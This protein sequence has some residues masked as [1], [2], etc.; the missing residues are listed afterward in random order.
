MKA[1][2]AIRNL[3]SMMLS[4]LRSCERGWD[5]RHRSGGI[6]APVRRYVPECGSDAS[7][8]SSRGSCSEAPGIVPPLSSV[9]IKL[10]EA[11]AEIGD[12]DEPIGDEASSSRLGVA[13]MRALED[14]IAI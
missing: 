13:F 10:K 2:S 5:C 9:R 1:A 6:A 12:H 8:T 14:P 4:C 7:L 3:R 11:D